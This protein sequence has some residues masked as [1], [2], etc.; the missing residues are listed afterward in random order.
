MD[1]VAKKIESNNYFDPGKSISMQDIVEASQKKEAQEPIKEA[2]KEVM[3]KVIEEP[4][5]EY[6]DKPSFAGS[7]FRVDLTNDDGAGY[8]GTIFLGSE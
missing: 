3:K 6:L 5:A 2:T 8:V 1:K 7:G 4:M